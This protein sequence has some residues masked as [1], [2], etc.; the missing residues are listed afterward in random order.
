MRSPTTWDPSFDILNLA[1]LPTRAL[2]HVHVHVHKAACVSGVSSSFWEY[3]RSHFAVHKPWL[4]LNL[5]VLSR[6]SSSTLAF[7]SITIG[8]PSSNR[9]PSRFKTVP[10]QSCAANVRLAAFRLCYRS[11]I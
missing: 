1:P 11:L 10:D 8:Y 2:I 6:Q 9:L 4:C 3:C 7:D 5:A